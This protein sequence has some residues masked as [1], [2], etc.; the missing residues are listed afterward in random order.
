MTEV[1]KERAGAFASQTSNG[2]VTLEVDQVYEIENS[3]WGVPA[4]RFHIVVGGERAGTVSLRIGSSDRVIRYAGQIG[5][6]VHPR[7]QGRRLAERAVRLLL[8]LAKDHGLATLWVTCNP[9]NVASRRTLERLG[10][11]YVETV[12]LP[13]DYDSYAQGEREKCR[14]RLG[15]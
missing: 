3:P 7:F 8:P 4:Y 5:F 9:A 1:S 11:T 2:E 14:F 15:A 10:A 13:P 12:P 6:G